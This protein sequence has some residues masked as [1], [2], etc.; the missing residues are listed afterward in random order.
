MF[1]A[2]SA[3][4]KR[5]LVARLAG[6]AGEDLTQ[7]T[8]LRLVAAPPADEIRLP[9]ALLMTVATNLARDEHRRQLR[10][11]G[12]HLSLD[13]VYAQD[14]PWSAADQETTLF[15]KQIVVS[16]PSLYRHVFVLSRFVGLDYAEIAER[17]GI[18]VKTVEW[19]MSKAL[20]H[21]AA[22]LR[23]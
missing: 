17:C 10:Q 11:G 12:A 20:A 22:Q 14:E 16:M 4:L 5:R 7:D 15:L 19:R 13:D 23:D 6:V 9:R 21:C 8:F 1:A 2:Q 3:W 18:S